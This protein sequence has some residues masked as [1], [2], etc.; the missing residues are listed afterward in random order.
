[1]VEKAETTDKT[2]PKPG[3]AAADTKEPPTSST[4]PPM[5][6][7][8]RVNRLLQIEDLHW[9]QQLQQAVSGS[10]FHPFV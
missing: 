4:A 2:D 9:K 7:V 3:L 10:L 5:D 8:S 1:M 6:E